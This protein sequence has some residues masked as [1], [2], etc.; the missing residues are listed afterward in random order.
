VGNRRRVARARFVSWLTVCCLIALLA[1]ASGAGADTARPREA[2]AGSV[3]SRLAE[4]PLSR[5]MSGPARRVLEF[6]NHQSPD[7]VNESMAP[8][9]AA[10]R[11][12]ALA[13]IGPNVR[14]NDPSGDGIG[15]PDMTTQSEPSLAVSGDN[16]V[17]G[18]NDDG[19]SSIFYTISP[20]THGRMTAEP[21]GRT[22]HCPILIPAST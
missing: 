6:L 3:T 22:R 5:W 4:H 13:P 2:D 19:K 1:V 18:Y 14:V 10:S 15:D 12:L 16:I 17:V 7:Q 9:A 20:A 21:L 11:A 8:D